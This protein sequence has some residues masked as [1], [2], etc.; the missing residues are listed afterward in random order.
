MAAGKLWLRTLEATAPLGL[1]STKPGDNF[2]KEEVGEKAEGGPKESSRRSYPRWFTLSSV[3]RGQP[4]GEAGV[5]LRAED[6]Q[7]RPLSL[8]GRRPS[9]TLAAGLTG[10]HMVLLLQTQDLPTKHLGAQP[11]Q[12]HGGHFG[13]L[14]MGREPRLSV[15]VLRISFSSKSHTHAILKLI[16]QSLQ[17]K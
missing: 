5:S 1:C 14:P 3:A 4:A 2:W 9:C 6:T 8:V 13:V 17:H 15:T 16:L 10:G 11:F 7:V 12:P